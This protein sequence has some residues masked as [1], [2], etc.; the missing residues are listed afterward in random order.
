LLIKYT[1]L[2]L[3]TPEIT[4]EHFK[5][6]LDRDFCTVCIFTIKNDHVD[7]LSNGFNRNAQL[8]TYVQRMIIHT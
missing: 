6:G 8:H 5:V 4:K 1:F 2:G 7:K 3:P